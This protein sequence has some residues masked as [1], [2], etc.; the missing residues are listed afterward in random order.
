MNILVI[1]QTSL[2]DV[3]NATGHLRAL[4]QQYPGAILTLLTDVHSE[5]I[6]RHN[7]W[8]D[9][10]ILIDRYGIKRNWWRQP[11][12]TI[13]EILRVRQEVRRREY[14]LALDLQGLAKSVLFLYWA[15]A[16]RKFVKGNW[17][18]I[19]GI[20]DKSLHA[21]VEMEEVLSLAGVR[22]ESTEM[23]LSAGEAE[24][25]AVDEKLGGLNPDS[26]PLIVISPFSRWASKDW[27]LVNYQPVIRAF[28]DQYLILLTGTSDRRGEIDGMLEGGPDLRA[29]NLAGSLS[30]LEFVELLD[31][32]DLVLTGDSFPMH[33]SAAL[34]TPV[35]A[36]FGPTDEKRVGPL[37]TRNRIIRVRDCRICHRR[38]CPHRCLERL[39]SEQVVLALR[40][41][42]EYLSAAGSDS[43]G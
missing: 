2:G 15:R 35:A 1:K 12:R 27:P 4:K 38:N 20:R 13:R 31:R 16:K 29:V 39:A 34:R 23:V 32:A 9:E 30:L 37:G 5:P 18:G 7:T 10:L 42:L 26:R 33:A 17:W 22:A 43:D 11:A 28:Q 36:I 24:K 41:H 3:L 8:V 25:R 14:D 6:L 21:L 40:S 19:R